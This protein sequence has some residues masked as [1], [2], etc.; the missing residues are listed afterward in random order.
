MLSIPSKSL[1]M[2]FKNHTK[3]TLLITMSVD[4][5]KLLILLAAIFA[6]LLS[7]SELLAASKCES[8][9]IYEFL[10]GKCHRETD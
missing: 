10:F 3:C 2:G 9:S 4:E 7:I 6:F 5:E 1:D 8:N